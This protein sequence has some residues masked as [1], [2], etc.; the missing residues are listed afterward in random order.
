MSPEAL[1]SSLFYPEAT[2]F[3]SGPHSFLLWTITVAFMPP[4]LPS[5]SP[6]SHSSQ[7]ELSET[8]IQSHHGVFILEIC[9]VSLFTYNDINPLTLYYKSPCSL[10]FAF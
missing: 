2:A 3:S 5:F 6:Y 10:S 4:A 7:N 1:P 8:H 9:F